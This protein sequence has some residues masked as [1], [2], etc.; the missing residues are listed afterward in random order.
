MIYNK[1]QR[2]KRIIISLDT[3]RIKRKS[4]KLKYY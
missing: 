3:K 2:I 1:A 4:C